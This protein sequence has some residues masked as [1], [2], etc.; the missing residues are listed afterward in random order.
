MTSA[1]KTPTRVFNETFARQM[2]NTHSHYGFFCLFC[3]LQNSDKI[4]P[5][6][7]NY[8]YISTAFLFLIGQVLGFTLRETQNLANL[9]KIRMCVTEYLWE[10]SIPCGLWTLNVGL[11]A[12]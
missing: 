5:F 12:D 4:I 9:Q 11:P 2:Q 8:F 10:K 6:R 7:K 1:S 3:C